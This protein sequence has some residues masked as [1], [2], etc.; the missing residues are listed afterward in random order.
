MGA[1][2]GTTRDWLEVKAVWSGV[3]ITLIDTAGIRATDDPVEQRGIA[4]GEDRVA[5]TDV[6][7]VV[8]D[9]A[10]WDE[11]ARPIRWLTGYAP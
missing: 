8:N 10:L 9:G 1:A 11:G 5:T 3:A 4:L 2:P 6:V 7:V